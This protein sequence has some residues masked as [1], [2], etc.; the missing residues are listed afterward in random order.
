MPPPYRPKSNTGAIVTITLISVLVV[1]GGFIGFAA[2]MDGGKSKSKS[3]A[4]SGYDYSTPTPTTSADGPFTT[5]T[6]PTTTTTTTTYGTPTGRSTPTQTRTQTQTTPRGP[7]PVRKTKD[8]PLFAGENGTNV[9]TCNLP[10]WQS[11]AAAAQAFFTAAAPCL[12]NAWAP[13]MQRANLPFSPPKIVFPQGKRF[14]TGCGAV[15]EKDNFAAFYCGP[16]AT[17]YMPFEGLQTQT[18]GAKIGA[19]LA[20]FAH[21]YG[22]HIQA[23]SGSLGAV[24]DQMYEVG[25]DSAAGLELQRRKEL[26]AQCLGGMWFAGAWNGKGSITDQVSRDM[27]ADGYTRGDDNNPNSPRDHGKRANYGAW[28]EQGYRKNRTFQCNTYLAPA[29][30]VS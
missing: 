27:L 5:T 8:N 28:Q 22:H 11:T 16:D 30:S 23:L 18:N 13:V 15:T 17:I 2:A 4:D 19:Y 10:R 26:Q 24:F 9:V 21:E 1:V 7:V 25:P 12:Q 3:V 6:Q 29:N 14:S 20:V